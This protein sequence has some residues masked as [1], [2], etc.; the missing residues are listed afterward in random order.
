M[1]M[2]DGMCGACGKADVAGGRVSIYKG[3]S[4][5]RISDVCLAACGTILAMTSLSCRGGADSSPWLH[6]YRHY[7]PAWHMHTPRLIS[8][9]LPTPST[10]P[11][12][13]PSCVPNPF[14]KKKKQKKKPTTT[15]EVKTQ[16]LSWPHMTRCLNDSHALPLHSHCL[17]KVLLLLKLLNTDV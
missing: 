5:L 1:Y 15:K 16:G 2:H 7:Q 14:E 10:A 17:I 3:Q 4:M 6:H 9:P 8:P 12:R 11:P 13:P